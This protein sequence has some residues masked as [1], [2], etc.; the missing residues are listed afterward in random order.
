MALVADFL[1]VAALDPAVESL[2]PAPAPARL[3]LGAS[4]WPLR[5]RTGAGRR[6]L[7]PVK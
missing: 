6:G 3:T 4:A 2:R 5:G 7:D 1:A